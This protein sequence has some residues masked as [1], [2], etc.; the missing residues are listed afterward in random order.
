M[1]NWFGIMA[2]TAFGLFLFASC[3]TTDVEKAFGS[4]VGGKESN[5]VIINYCMSC[6]THQ[7]FDAAAHVPAVQGRYAGSANAGA[8]EC[9]ACHTYSINW[10]GDEV[11]G[12]HWIA[13]KEP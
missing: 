10:V 4:G 7:S 5:K 3:A 13:V 11:R 8:T 12:T 2:V 6:H 9:R 1:G